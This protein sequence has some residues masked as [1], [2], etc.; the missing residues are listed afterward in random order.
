MKKRIIPTALAALL[1]AASAFDNTIWTF[2]N[3]LNTQTGTG[4]HAAG[5]M[6]YGK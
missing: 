1:P 2:E 4:L 5:T 6:T 3:S